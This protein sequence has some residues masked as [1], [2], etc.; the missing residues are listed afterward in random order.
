LDLV[1]RLPRLWALVVAHRVPV[2]LARE[3]ARESRDLCVSAA[4]HADELL[5]W[6]PKDLN[7]HRVKTL[8][9]EARLYADPDRAAADHDRALARRRVT[10]RHGD[11]APGTSDVWMTL[12]TADAV[13]FD[14]AV[15]RVADTMQALGHDGT[16]DVRRVHAV[17]VIADPQRALDLLAARD[18]PED[19]WETSA[20]VVAAEDAM[21]QPVSPF[22]R[23][24]EFRDHRQARSGREEPG[25][26]RA[27]PDRPRPRRGGHAPT[28]AMAD[29]IRTTEPTCAFP[30]CRRHHGAKTFGG[31]AYRRLPDGAYEWTLPSGRILTTDPPAPRPTPRPQS[32]RTPG[33]GVRRCRSPAE[34]QPCRRAASSRRTALGPTP[35]RGRSSRRSVGRSATV[36]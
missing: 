35:C 18:L 28:A 12:D 10:V 32:R 31:Y 34:D 20:T 23:R 9:H 36:R 6:R 26:A 30:S 8:V 2:W 22:R 14:T 11:G 19:E 15:T 1:F 33:P 29:Y 27:A 25:R 5:S 17:G 21:C 7:P 24:E 3:A 16:V 13:V 4:K